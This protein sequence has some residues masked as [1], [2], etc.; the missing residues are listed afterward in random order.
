MF[1][2][3]LHC[4][5]QV[6]VN[7]MLAVFNSS[8]CVFC[9]CCSRKCGLFFSTQSCSACAVCMQQ[10]CEVSGVLSVTGECESL[11]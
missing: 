7:P 5:K 10:W 1:C 8:C 2:L 3:A 4:F 6:I 11:V 9:C